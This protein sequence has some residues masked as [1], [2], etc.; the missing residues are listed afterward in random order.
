[1]AADP[2]DVRTMTLHPDEH[3]STLISRIEEV[4]ELINHGESDKGRYYQAICSL[5][6]VSRELEALRVYLR[7]KRLGLPV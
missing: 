7:A 2:K 1:M 5:G 4:S 3:L 6:D